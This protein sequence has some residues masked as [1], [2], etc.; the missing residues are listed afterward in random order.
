MYILPPAS[1]HASPG[2]EFVECCYTILQTLHPLFI[3]MYVMMQCCSCRVHAVIV[4][5]VDG[6]FLIAP[7]HNMYPTYALLAFSE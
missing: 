4:H 1:N 2:I 6:A 5:H 3:V 7:C